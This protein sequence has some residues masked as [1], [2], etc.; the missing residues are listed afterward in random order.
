M[1]FFTRGTA[2]KGNTK[3]VWIYDFRSEMPSFGK[4]NPLKE[5]HFDEFVE[6]YYAEDITARQKTYSED[7][8]N[9]RWRKYTYD[10]ILERDK[11]S[12]DVSWIKS[13]NTS[14]DYTLSELL[15][16]QD[17]VT[18]YCKCSGRTGKTD[19]RGRRI[20]NTKA[21]RQ[22]IFNLAI[23]SKLVPQDPNDEPA[24]VLLVIINKKSLNSV[25]FT[26]KGLFYLFRF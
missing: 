23:R 6:C 25:L 8:P 24:S 9:G 12:L 18:K 10:D 14:D 16:N 26:A 4:T 19:W 5:S 1:L 13:V 15:A 11:T 22:K 21:L 7:N 17:K 2:D 3:E 20:M